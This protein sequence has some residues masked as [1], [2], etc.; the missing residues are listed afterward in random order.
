LLES[1]LSETGVFEVGRFVGVLTNA[2]LVERVRETRRLSELFSDLGRQRLVFVKQFPRTSFSQNQRS[3]N[4]AK[5]NVP[6][7]HAIFSFG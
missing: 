3:K 2:W 6:E 5:I 1:F 7:T 4:L